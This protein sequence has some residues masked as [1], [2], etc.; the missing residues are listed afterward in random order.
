MKKSGEIYTNNNITINDDNIAFIYQDDSFFS[1]LTVR[2][3]LKLAG[4]LRLY[5]NIS[6]VIINNV[7]Q[8]LG[9]EDVADTLVGNWNRFWFYFISFWYKY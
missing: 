8:Y 6:N 4:S 7:I 5:N 2:E 3:T 9:L 1:Q